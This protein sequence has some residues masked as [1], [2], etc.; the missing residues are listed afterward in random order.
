MIA[1]TGS[2]TPTDGDGSAIFLLQL[3]RKLSSSRVDINL[4]QVRVCVGA[5]VSVRACVFGMCAHAVCVCVCVCVCLCVC[6]LVCVW[7]FLSLVIP[8]IEHFCTP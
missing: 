3:V 2:A 5:C 4:I 6:V 1:I 8:D 7:C